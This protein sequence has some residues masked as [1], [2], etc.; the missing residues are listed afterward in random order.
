MRGLH[1][2]CVWNFVAA[3][4]FGQLVGDS[5]THRHHRDWPLVGECVAVWTSPPKYVL[6]YTVQFEASRYHW[7]ASS[8]DGRRLEG[9]GAAIGPVTYKGNEDGS[10]ITQFFSASRIQPNPNE[11]T[12]CSCTYVRVSGKSPVATITYYTVA[13]VPNSTHMSMLTACNPHRRFCPVDNRTAF[14]DIGAPFVEE[15]VGCASR[16]VLR[17]VHTA[18]LVFFYLLSAGGLLII[19]MMVRSKCGGPSLCTVSSHRQSLAGD[20][21]Q[22]IRGRTMNEWDFYLKRWSTPSTISPSSS[23]GS[24][25]NLDDAWTSETSP[26]RG[27]S[28]RQLTSQSHCSSTQ[29][30]AD[31][32][33]KPLLPC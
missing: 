10:S 29:L 8:A 26:S 19:L 14:A 22:Q 17:Q 4:A 3:A 27:T 13:S 30:G 12:N 2:I 21:S 7:K 33:H 24:L 31:W 15:Y 25:L 5:F 1:C 6:P 28:S 32:L 11:A 9:E 18:M 16:A 20:M 23:T